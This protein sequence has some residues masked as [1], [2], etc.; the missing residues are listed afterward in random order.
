V[1]GMTGVCHRI[2]LSRPRVATI[3]R[4][5]QRIISWHTLASSPFISIHT[6]SGKAQLDNHGKNQ[7]D[8]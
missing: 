2:L 6:T 4:Q 3:S 1:E 8:R 7:A 5:Q